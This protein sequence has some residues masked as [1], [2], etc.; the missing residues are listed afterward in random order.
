MELAVPKMDQK[1]QISFVLGSNIIKI[2]ENDRVHRFW[3][4]EGENIPSNQEYSIFHDNCADIVQ[5]PP[6]QHNL[7]YRK[8]HKSDWVD[9]H[10]D[11]PATNIKEAAG[12]YM[13]EET[14]PRVSER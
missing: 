6:Y 11:M 10:M 7:P 1:P 14:G 13:W 5:S 2:I 12:E 3:A 9:K 8:V 4:H